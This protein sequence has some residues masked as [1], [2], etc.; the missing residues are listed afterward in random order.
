[1][2][3]HLLRYQGPTQFTKYDSINVDAS[4]KAVLATSGEIHVDVPYYDAKRTTP[5][6]E[7]DIAILNFALALEYLEAAFYNTN[8]PLFT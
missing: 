7:N 1:M 5:S 6:A 2:W 4:G 3:N 8:E